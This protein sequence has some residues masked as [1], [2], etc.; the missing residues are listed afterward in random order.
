MDSPSWAARVRYSIVGLPSARVQ[1]KV[2]P[3]GGG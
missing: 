1:I 3:R 2:V